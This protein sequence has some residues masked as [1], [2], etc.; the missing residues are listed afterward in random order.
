MIKDL[1]INSPDDPNYKFIF[2]HS[3]PIISIL[4]KIKMILGTRQGQVLGDLNFGIGIEDLVFETRINSRDLEEKIRMQIYQYITE[5]K[6]YSIQPRVSFG[7]EEGY[8]YCIID[9]II[10]NAK[11][12]GILVK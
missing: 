2:E 8:D 4:T 7:R 6:D 11:V 9:I 5:A 10:N 3:D 12:A 1:Y